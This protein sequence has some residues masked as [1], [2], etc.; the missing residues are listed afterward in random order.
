MRNMQ[1]FNNYK[2]G[3]EKDIFNATWQYIIDHAD[4]DR[5]GVYFVKFHTNGKLEFAK[6]IKQRM[7]GIYRND[8]DSMTGL[9]EQR[10]KEHQ[11]SILNGMKRAE[12]K[13]KIKSQFAPNLKEL[14]KFKTAPPK[15]TLWRKF[16]LWINSLTNS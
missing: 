6:H 7:K 1:R 12:E 16:V 13:K 9:S 10:K 2:K 3:V 14:Q 15:R 11:Q 5:Q 4:I 8:L